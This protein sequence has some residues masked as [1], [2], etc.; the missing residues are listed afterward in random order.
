MIPQ[1]RHQLLHLLAAHRVHH[2]RPV[3][4]GHGHNPCHRV[5][6]LEQTLAFLGWLFLYLPLIELYLNVELS[7]VV[8]G[9]Q[10]EW[11][12]V[13]IALVNGLHLHSLH[14]GDFKRAHVP[15]GRHPPVPHSEL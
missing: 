7:E 5:N 9:S 11:L 4:Q 12:D 6:V 14:V 15:V 2:L 13:E 10:V 3:Q 1:E 8:N